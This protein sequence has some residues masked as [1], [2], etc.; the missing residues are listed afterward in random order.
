MRDIQFLGICIDYMEKKY[1]FVNFN[2]GRENKLKEI[3]LTFPDGG[4]RAPGL[5]PGF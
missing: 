1:I 4:M 3:T 5:E 2:S